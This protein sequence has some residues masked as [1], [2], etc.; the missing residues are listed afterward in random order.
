MIDE[1][2]FKQCA[3]EVQEGFDLGGLSD[4]LYFDFALST[5]N[6]YVQ[7]LQGGDSEELTVPELCEIVGEIIRDGIT[8]A[9]ELESD[10][11]RM[12]EG[13]EMILTGMK[14]G[15]DVVRRYIDR[16]VSVCRT[17]AKTDDPELNDN[18]AFVGSTMIERVLADHISKRTEKK[19]K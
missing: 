12:P 5:A 14:R 16:F 11:M 9:F 17:P 2:L 15:V 19:G 4:G 3:E 6:L 10:Q 13:G 7:K 1:E 8:R 18:Y